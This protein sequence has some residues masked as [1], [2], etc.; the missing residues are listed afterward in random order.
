MLVDLH[1][2]STASDGVDAPAEVARQAASRGIA[3]M[4]LTD[5]DSADGV[6]EA[7]ATATQAG[8]ALIPGV[9]LSCE[10]ALEVHLLGYGLDPA[11]PYWTTFFEDLQTER[12]ERARRMLTLLADQGVVLAVDA[13]F[14]S[15]AHALSRSH[16][17]RALVDAGAARSVKEAFTRYLDPGRPAYL[18]RPV[19]PVA[20]AARRLRERGAVP[21]LAHPGLLR[22]SAEAVTAHIHGWR[23]AGLE[24]VEAHHPRHTPTQAAAFERLARSLDMLVTGGSDTHGEAVRPTRIGE[25]MSAWGRRDADALA[26]WRRCPHKVGHVSNE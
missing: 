26:L 5:H 24:G 6:A 16:I 10:G 1:L 11:E 9:E 17:A 14:G 23:E 12:R 25:G 4:A 21:V 8:V 15:V 18:P 19:L 3:L 22:M 2:H 20:E 7:S 13:L